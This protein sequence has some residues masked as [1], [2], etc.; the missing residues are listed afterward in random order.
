MPLLLTQKLVLYN[1]VDFE[2]PTHR[3][4]SHQWR[5][6]E[7]D[8]N[9]MLHRRGDLESHGYRKISGAYQLARLIGFSRIWI[10]TCCINKQSSAELIEATNSIFNYYSQARLCIVHLTDMSAPSAARTTS[11]EDPP[12]LRPH[13]ATVISILAGG[14][15][16]SF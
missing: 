5:N 14:H 9:T 15:S 12:Y 3:I 4:L 7:V 11:V 1:F 8:Y 6:D 10:D 2:V 13:F 16:K